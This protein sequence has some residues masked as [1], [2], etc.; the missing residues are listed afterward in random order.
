MGRYKL[1]NAGLWIIDGRWVKVNCYYG[2]NSCGR[3]GTGLDQIR[4]FEHINANVKSMDVF[5]FEKMAI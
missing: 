4:L 2:W 3:G 5:K 1:L